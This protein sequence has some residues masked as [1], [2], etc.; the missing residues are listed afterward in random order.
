MIRI[1]GNEN[2]PL[3]EFVTKKIKKFKNKKNKKCT[4]KLT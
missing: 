4:K 2:D 3:L 1:H